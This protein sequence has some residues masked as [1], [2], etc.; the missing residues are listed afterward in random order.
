MKR[1]LLIFLLTVLPL[2]MSLAA[3]T[4]YCQHENG[5]AAQHLGHHEHKHKASDESQPSK[6]KLGMNDADCGYCHLSCGNIVS[7][8][9]SQLTF[10][11]FSTPVEF[12]LY[13]YSSHIPDGLAKPD[14]RLAI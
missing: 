11:K 10:S 13:P 8:L 1:L 3:V 2:Q 9:Q 6:G 14:W 5:K 7:T 4:S 12:Q